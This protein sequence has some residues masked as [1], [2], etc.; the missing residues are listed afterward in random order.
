MS[1]RNVQA[2]FR[3]F[4]D[5]DDAAEGACHEAAMKHG[6][7]DRADSCDDMELACPTCPWRKNSGAATRGVAGANGQSDAS[8]SAPN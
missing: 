4:R 3:L 6:V 7:A 5:Q 1:D 2:A 8:S